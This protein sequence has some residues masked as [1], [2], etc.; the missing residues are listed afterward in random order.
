MKHNRLKSQLH[1]VAY[2]YDR[3]TPGFRDEIKRYFYR[4]K[5]EIIKDLPDHREPNVKGFARPRLVTFSPFLDKLIDRH[6][7]AKFEFLSIR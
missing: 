5:T 3:T 4:E 6:A 1:V 2:L 7:F